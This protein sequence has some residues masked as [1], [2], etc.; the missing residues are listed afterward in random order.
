MNTDTFSLASQLSNYGSLVLPANNVTHVSEL[1]DDPNYLRMRKQLVGDGTLFTELLTSFSK[2]ESLYEQ[3]ADFFNAISSGH[4]DH[5]LLST[6][7]R[8]TLHT[9]VKELN[10]QKDTIPESFM[11]SMLY[12][13]AEGVS[14]CFEG[15]FAR[16]QDAKKI[17]KAHSKG[18]LEGLTTIVT[19]SL[20]HQFT[21]QFLFQKRLTNELAFSK[22]DAVHVHNFFYNIVCNQ[23]GLEVIKDD[24]AVRRD[25]KDSVIEE[26]FSGVNFLINRFH[27]VRALKENIYSQVSVIFSENKKSHLLNSEN[28]SAGE[29]ISELLNDLECGPLS[30]CKAVEN[31]RALELKIS[32]LISINDDNTYS[33]AHFSE[34]MQTWLALRHKKNDPEILEVIL[35]QTGKTQYIGSIDNL[36]FWVFDPENSS[37]E[38]LKKGHKCTFDQENYTSLQLSHLTSFHAKSL[39]ET[40]MYALLLQA[41]DQTNKAEDVKKFFLDMNGMDILC[42]LPLF[43]TEELSEALKA[44]ADKDAVFKN[45]LFRVFNEHLEKS[46]LAEPTTLLELFLFNLHKRK[47]GDINHITKHMNA[48]HIRDFSEAAIRKL[49]SEGDC[50]QLFYQACYCQNTKI[51][52]HIL[53][54]G[55][56]SGLVNAP[57]SSGTPLMLAA[58]NDALESVKALLEHGADANMRDPEGYTPLMLAA[59]NSALESVKAL[60]EHGADANM[61]DPEGYTALMLAAQNGHARCTKALSQYTDIN[62]RNKEGY[63]ALMFAVL[64][65]NHEVF[66]C[67]LGGKKLKINKQDNIG[68]TALMLAAIHGNSDYVLTLLHKNADPNKKNKFGD[69]ALMAAI[70]FN[71]T[72]C[73]KILL[74][75]GAKPNIN[76]VDDTTPLIVAAI[77][78]ND[79]IVK[80]LLDQNVKIDKQD[81]DGQ[82]ALMFAVE[83]GHIICTQTLLARGAN[84]TKKSIFLYTAVMFASKQGHAGC[85]EALLGTLEKYDQKKKIDHLN[86][87]ARKHGHTALMLATI[88]KNPL[89]VKKLLVYGADVDKTC[90]DGGTAL[91]FAVRNSDTNIVALLMEHNANI[92]IRTKKGD[93][94]LKIAAQMG[95]HEIIQLLRESS[96]QTVTSENLLAAIRDARDEETRNLLKDW[97]WIKNDINKS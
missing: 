78:G 87:K 71:H 23:F 89:C 67:L 8:S 20:L 68:R 88:N 66:N 83:Q 53:A 7:Y 73:A 96:L 3:V 27:T 24:Y 92:N 75:K 19:E 48:W 62:I 77:V 38:L 90:K 4:S 5:V 37:T 65:D 26:Y 74:T 40:D 15:N 63:T 79:K 86:Q 44:K 58:E 76:N 21:S 70:Q 39:P 32:D 85:L 47:Q 84:V 10:R 28:V 55:F 36:F 1:K 6:V 82:T 51:M 64:Q 2:D 50:I 60:L 12:R 22:G 81:L 11:F 18:G 33:L 13:Y 14:A 97:I 91:I 34:H 31:G 59:A 54:T 43:I 17:L 94:A 25:I 61:R 46:E 35:D 29:L 95:H 69:T 56:C 42:G 80:E 45:E 52:Q 16:L 93:T 30:A 9:F 57:D 72:T 49:F 41:L